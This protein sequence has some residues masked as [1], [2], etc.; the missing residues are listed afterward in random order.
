MGQ[1]G[2]TSIAGLLMSISNPDCLFHGRGNSADAYFLIQKV[3]ASLGHATYL[4]VMN[5]VKTMTDQQI[6]DWLLPIVGQLK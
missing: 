5:Q 6:I 2:F 3:R 4:S 1:D